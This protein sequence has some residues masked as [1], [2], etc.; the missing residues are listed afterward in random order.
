MELCREG[1]VKKLVYISSCSVYG[2]ADYETDQLVTEDAS[3]ERYPEKRGNY[4]ASKQEAESFVIEEMGKKS[5][6]IVILRPGSIFG[7]GG[8]IF[9]GMLGF[10]LK[11]KAFIVIG[12]GKFELPFV[13]VDN[14]VDAI[15]KSIKGKK[16]DNKIFNIVD[17]EKVDKRLYMEKLVKK[18]YP[19]TPVFYFPYK[20]LDGITFCQE[21]FF[22]LLKRNPVLTRY[23]LTSSQRNVRYDNS[24]ITETL[25][26]TPKVSVDDALTAIYE[27]EKERQR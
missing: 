10:S 18:L 24:K 23:R 25:K 2:V 1:G 4:S 3:L 12:N 11:G 8:D 16:A 9:T 19:G 26:W 17:S 22:K 5:F 21:L 13:Y 20:L 6:P 7:P 14:L 15:I 27:Y